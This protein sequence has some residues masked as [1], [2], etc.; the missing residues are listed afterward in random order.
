MTEVLRRRCLLQGACAL[1]LGLAGG[2]VRGQ[3]PVGN[4]AT[5]TNPWA[6]LAF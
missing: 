4:A 3:A 5:S 2:A 1:G 6:N